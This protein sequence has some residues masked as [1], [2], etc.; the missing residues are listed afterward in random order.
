MR[1]LLSPSVHNGYGLRVTAHVLAIDAHC[2]V[3]GGS[4][5]HHIALGR[6]HTVRLCG[7]L[8]VSG[9]MALRGMLHWRLAT[10]KC[11]ISKPRL[12]I[13]MALDC[14]QVDD[15]STALG[16]TLWFATNYCGEAIYV[17]PASMNE[18]V[19]ERWNE[20]TE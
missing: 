1:M 18:S 19:N 6:E 17:Q 9:S 10:A 15:E 14:L 7:A 12:S 5:V 13:P 8:C 11:R 4:E 2:P 20:L 3:P 16:D